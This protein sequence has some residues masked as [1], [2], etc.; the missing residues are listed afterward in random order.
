[1]SAAAPAPYHRLFAA[2]S[3][4]ATKAGEGRAWTTGWRLKCRR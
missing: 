4:L 3:T 2:Y 1:M